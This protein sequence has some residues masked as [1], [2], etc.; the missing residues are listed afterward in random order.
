MAKRK[1]HLAQRFQYL[2]SHLRHPALMLGFV[3]LLGSFNFML[4]TAFPCGTFRGVPEFGRCN[5]GGNFI[6]PLDA[7]LAGLLVGFII[8]IVI[9]MQ[10]PHDQKWSNFQFIKRIIKD[11]S[12]GPRWRKK[13]FLPLFIITYLPLATLMYFM[14]KNSGI[15]WYHYASQFLLVVPIVSSTITASLLTQLRKL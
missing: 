5:Y 4:F 9:A 15:Y 11:I 12:S 14:D 2:L 10:S 6:S 13:W 7:L 8:Y 1:I 3:F